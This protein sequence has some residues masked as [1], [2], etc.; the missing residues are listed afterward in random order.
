MRKFKKGDKVKGL[1]NTRLIGIVVDVSAKYDPAERCVS[2]KWKDFE[3]IALER[4]ICIAL[5][6]GDISSFNPDICTDLIGRTIIINDNQ[7]CLQIKE[8][9]LYEVKGLTNDNRL[10]LEAE[11][12]PIEWACED[13]S[14]YK[15]FTLTGELLSPKAQED[16]EV[17]QSDKTEQQEVSKEDVETKDD[18]KNI[19]NPLRYNSEIFWGYG[20]TAPSRGRYGRRG[21]SDDPKF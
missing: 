7:G 20:K 15:H 10:I 3:P 17:S 11:G 9:K 18:Q 13:N 16:E 19:V 1:I 14:Q 6:S 8:G 12:Q 5:I 21:T 2:V 4:P